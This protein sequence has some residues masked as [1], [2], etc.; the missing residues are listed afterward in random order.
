M[1]FATAHSQVEFKEFD[2]MPKYGSIVIKILKS[3]AKSE[4]VFHEADSRLR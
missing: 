4:R 3:L 1:N 2:V